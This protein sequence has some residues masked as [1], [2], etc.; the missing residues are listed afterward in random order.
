MTSFQGAPQ[1]SSVADELVVAYDFVE[2]SGAHPGGQRLPNGRRN[3]DGLLFAVAVCRGVGSPR[4]HGPMLQADRPR[5]SERIRIGPRNASRRPMGRGDAVTGYLKRAESGAALADRH[6]VQD[7]HED[8]DD[9][10]DARQ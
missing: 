2:G 10:K 8:E 3:E 7:V 5:R 9:S 6:Y 1:G 4:C